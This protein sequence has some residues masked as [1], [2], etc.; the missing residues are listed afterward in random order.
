VNVFPS[1]AGLLSLNSFGDGIT[2]CFNHFANGIVLGRY[3]GL[4]NDVLTNSY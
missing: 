4:N 3:F 2:A 1:F